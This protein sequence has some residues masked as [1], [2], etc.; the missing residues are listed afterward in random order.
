MTGES[1][2][3]SVG[4]NR[5]TAHVTLCP[6]G[7]SEL[8]A[9]SISFHVSLTWD[10]ILSTCR[11]ADSII[12]FDTAIQT[13]PTLL[14]GINILVSRTDSTV[15]PIPEWPDSTMFTSLTYRMAAWRTRDATFTDIF[16][17]EAIQEQQAEP[18]R[19]L[20]DLLNDPGRRN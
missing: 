2:T 19:K 9:G 17:Q 15:I 5:A 6:P 10:S 3:R 13:A 16:R 4:P 14:K 12:R 20:R 1:F 11:V 8:D 7:K 18:I